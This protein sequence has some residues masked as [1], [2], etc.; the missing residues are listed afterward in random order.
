MYLPKLSETQKILYVFGELA[1]FYLPELWA[2]FNKEGIHQTMFLTEWVMT[3]FCRGFSF[4]LVTRVWDIFMFEGDMKIMYRVSLAILKYF[5]KEFLALR[6]DKIM[7]L[8][9]VIA[10]RLDALAVMDLAWSIPLRRAKIKFFE[11]QV[12]FFFF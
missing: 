3:F 9:R 4:E 6:F 1:N 7:T 10:Q 5:E 2:H 12:S 8:L 11:D